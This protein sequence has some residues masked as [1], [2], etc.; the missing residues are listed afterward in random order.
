MYLV[1][2]VFLF[3]KVQMKDEGIRTE[4]IIRYT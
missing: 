2:G 4:E 1:L 3:T